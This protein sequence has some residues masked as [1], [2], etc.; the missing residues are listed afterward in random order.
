[1]FTSCD[2]G[3]VDSLFYNSSIEEESDLKL[4]IELSKRS[5]IILDIGANTGVFSIV[6]A[7]SNPEARIYSFEPYSYNYNRLK[8]NVF[9][10]NC[11]S[12]FCFQKAIGNS[13]DE[14]DF[15]VP[16]KERIIDV[17]SVD[18]NFSKAFYGNEITWT[19]VKVNQTSIDLFQKEI[20]ENKSIDLMKID[21]ESY[22]MNVFKGCKE[23]LKSGTSVIILEIFPDEERITFFNAIMNEN[24]YYGYMILNEGILRLDDGMRANHDGR[25]FLLSK[26]KTSKIFTSFNSMKEIIDEII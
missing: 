12:I 17:S 5:K 20:L 22:E 15:Y 26:K 11:N 8:K 18:A 2:D 19:N 6:A 23:L 16:D 13:T 25:N 1:M 7:I 24:N 4:F 21:V 3:M 10:N 9:L 14:I